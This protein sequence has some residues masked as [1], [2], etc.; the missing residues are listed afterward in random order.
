VVVCEFNG[1][2]DPALA[3]TQ[4]YDPSSGWDETEFYGASLK[5][6]VELGRHKG[7]TLVHTDLTGTNAFFVVDEHA[8]A[9]QDCVPVPARRVQTGFTDFRHKPDA[10]GRSFHR[11]DPAVRPAPPGGGDRP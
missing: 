11:P 6:L 9:F 5:A 4:P 3:L 1:A 7:Y 10:K 2:L 8:G